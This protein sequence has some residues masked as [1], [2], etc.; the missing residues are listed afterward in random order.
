MWATVRNCAAKKK[1]HNYQILSGADRRLLLS[2]CEAPQTGRNAA[3]SAKCAAGI[4]PRTSKSP[5]PPSSVTDGP[6]LSHEMYCRNPRSQ[7][8]S[9]ASNQQI[10]TG[11]VKKKRQRVWL[12]YFKYPP[13]FFSYGFPLSGCIYLSCLRAVLAV[14]FPCLSPNR[15][16][17]RYI[18]RRF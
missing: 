3:P 14:S 7:M 8:Y 1:K 12:K 16:L 9:D 15:N 10:N 17:D 5:P 18:R 13:L 4:A 11:R 6:P 2:A